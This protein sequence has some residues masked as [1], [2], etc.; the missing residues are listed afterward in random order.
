MEILKSENKKIKIKIQ[1]FNP[2]NSESVKSRRQEHRTVP[3]VTAF[4]NGEDGR[5]RIGVRIVKN[6]D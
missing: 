3:Q 6:G 4:H 2:R 1:G 5:G